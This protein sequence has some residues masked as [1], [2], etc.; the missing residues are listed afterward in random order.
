MTR[1]TFGHKPARGATEV[2]S[3]GLCPTYDSSS[4]HAGSHNSKILDAQLTNPKGIDVC[5]PLRT[6]L[7]FPSLTCES[8]GSREKPIPMLL[9]L[10]VLHFRQRRFTCLA[11]GL[12]KLCRARQWEGVRDP[13]LRS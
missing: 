6:R 2:F 9:G 7:V 10:R 8:P 12:L 5:A 1:D 13:T 4:P 11:D 3:V